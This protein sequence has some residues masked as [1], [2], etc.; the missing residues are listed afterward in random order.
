MKKTNKTLLVMLFTF[1]IAMC[2]TGCGKEKDELLDYVNGDARK[3]LTELEKKAKESYS[4]VSGDNY[5]DDQ[6]M[7]DELSKNTSD[8][9]KQTVDKATSI[10]GKLEGEQLKKVHEMYVTALKDLQSGVDELV[11]AL[12]NGDADLASKA[13]ET[14]GKA[15]EGETKYIEE[16]KKLGED[17]GVEVTTSDE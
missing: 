16:L 15:N 13:N 6:T 7:L 2:M 11:Q 8:L 17:L 9:L 10:G 5:K 1:I 3:E 12:E 4:S 14:I